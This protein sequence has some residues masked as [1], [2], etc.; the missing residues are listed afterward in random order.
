MADTKT[1]DPKLDLIKPKADR[2]EPP[3]TEH[4]DATK[5][6][7]L[8]GQVQHL[9]EQLAGATRMR[10]QLCAEAVGAV[11]DKYGC[12]LSMGKNGIGCTTLTR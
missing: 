10:E 9:Q 12:K 5:I 2:A 3:Q 7:R 6:R 11:L 1:D 8:E 4:D